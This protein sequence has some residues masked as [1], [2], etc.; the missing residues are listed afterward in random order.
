LCGIAVPNCN[1]GVNSEQARE[2]ICAG[3][4]CLGQNGLDV[5]CGM[6]PRLGGTPMLGSKRV[7]LAV[8]ALG[9]SAGCA[10][11]ADLSSGSAPSYKDGP[12]NYWVVTIGGYAS[13]DPAFPGAKETDYV[14]SGRPILDSHRAGEREWLSLPNDAFG[15]GLYNA[16]N[17][18]VGVAG[19]FIGRRNRS[20]APNALD[21]VH[22]IDYTF[23]AGGF[24]EYYPAPFLRTRVELLQGFTGAEGFE[25][26]LMADFIYRASPQLTFTAGP[27]LQIV[28]NKYASAFFSTANLELPL[29]PAYNAAGGLN[30]AGIDVTARYDLTERFSVRAFGEWNRLLGDA[31]DSALVKQRGS[32][33]QLQVGLGAAYKFNFAW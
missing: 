21:G 6:T 5:F 18:R 4:E 19:D 12:G 25:A 27:R 15:I 1:S 11:G 31:A 3:L 8:A 16:G 9:L 33:D 24:A 20:D 14:W 7:A 22:N 10:F 32:A 28:D 13:I 29:T 26:N 2:E 17:F 30:A 23:E